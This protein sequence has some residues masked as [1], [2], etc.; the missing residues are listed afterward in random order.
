L[1]FAIHLPNSWS[2]SAEK[3]AKVVLGRALAVA[4]VADMIAKRVV[5]RVMVTDE[6]ISSREVGFHRGVGASSYAH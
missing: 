6:W 3:G 5:I 2:V 4:A 1:S